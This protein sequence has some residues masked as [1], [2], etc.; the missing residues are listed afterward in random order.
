MTS[1]SL[2]NEAS[3]DDLNTR[4]KEPIKARQFRNNFVIK[5]AKPYDEDN[6]EWIKIGESVFRNTMPCTRCL[7]TTIDPDTGVMN[8]RRDPLDTLKTYVH[9]FLLNSIIVK[10]FDNIIQP[11]F[12]YRQLSDPKIRSAIGESPAMGLHLGFRGKEGELVKV[13][14]PV[15]VGL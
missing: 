15:Y 2:V 4:L 12:S 9:N 14:D 7:L 11:N 5:G 10:I 3:V 1:Y 13:G 6:W 8:K